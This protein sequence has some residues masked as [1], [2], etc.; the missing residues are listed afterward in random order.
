MSG[1]KSTRGKIT[2]REVYIHMDEEVEGKEGRWGSGERERER[3]RER[4]MHTSLSLVLWPLHHLPVLP[5]QI[6]WLLSP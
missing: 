3:E 1:M 6:S 5:H 4:E 2:R